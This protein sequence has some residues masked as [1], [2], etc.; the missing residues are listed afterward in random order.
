MADKKICQIS[1][2]DVV[3]H[4]R[5]YCRRHYGMVWRKDRERRQEQVELPEGTSRDDMEKLRAL[6]REFRR[7]E[8]MYNVV[9]GYEGRLKWRREMDDVKAEILKIDQSFFKNT[10][11][12]ADTQA[13]NPEV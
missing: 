12:N 13:Q 4:A 7:A 3:A 8:Q 5:G 11:A 10:D 9:I 2:C 1:D 6:E